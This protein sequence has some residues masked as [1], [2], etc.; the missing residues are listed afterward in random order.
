A[1][2]LA[3]IIF[4]SHG[5]SRSTLSPYTTL[6][7]S[8]AAIVL[9]FTFCWGSLAFWAP[10]AAEEINSSTVRLLYQLKSFPLDGVGPVLLGGLMSVVPVGFLAWYPCRTLLGLV[11]DPWSRWLT[12]LVALLL[13]C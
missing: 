2:C 5:P 6:F 12:P 4:M 3:T 11:R 10:L 1:R 13:T 8:S 9:A 7:R